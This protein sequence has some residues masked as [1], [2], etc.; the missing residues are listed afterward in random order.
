MNDLA[1]SF[2]K[3]KI[4][5]GP[6]SLPAQAATNI[7]NEILG[8]RSESIQG[9]LPD[10]ETEEGRDAFNVRANNIDRETSLLTTLMHSTITATKANLRPTTSEERQQYASESGG[11]TQ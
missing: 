4:L 6:D 10:L 3:I 11:G 8:L 5:C 7:A 2:A 1:S 9:V